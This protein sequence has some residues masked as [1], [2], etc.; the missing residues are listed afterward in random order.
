MRKTLCWITLL[1]ATFNAG[2]ASSRHTAPVI[3]PAGVDMG[4]Y[5]ADLEACNQ[6]ARQV[7]QKAGAGA[8]GGVLVGALVGSIFGDS[9]SAMK[10]AGA[11]AVVGGAKGGAA[12]QREKAVVVKNCMRERGY[13]VLN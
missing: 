1:V 9:R 11:G 4:R 5:Q 8:A 2:C 12:T 3:D 13:K 10:S 7:Q 6:I